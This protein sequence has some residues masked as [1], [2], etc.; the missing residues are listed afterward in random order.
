MR[1]RLH[2]L[3]A[4]LDTDPTLVHRH[5]PELDCGSTGTR[6]LLLEGGTLLHVAAEFCSLD[7][8]RLLL[9]HG[10]DPNAAATPRGQTP[11]F[12]SATQNDDRG[13]AVTQ[14]LIDR[15]ADLSIRVKLPGYYERPDEIVD[16]TPLGYAVQFPGTQEKTIALLRDRGGVE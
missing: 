9:D 10:A 14:L 11:I 12:H 2:E 1:G 16:C 3:T 13:L 6:M 8:A 5:Y 7:A 4:L 15:G